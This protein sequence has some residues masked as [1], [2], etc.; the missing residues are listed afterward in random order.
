MHLSCYIYCH[1]IFNCISIKVDS[2]TLLLNKRTSRQTNGASSNFSAVGGVGANKFA[3]GVAN[4]ATRQENL[5]FERS[6]LKILWL[7]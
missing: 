7:I 5:K 1:I 3:H 4:I 2:P 6:E